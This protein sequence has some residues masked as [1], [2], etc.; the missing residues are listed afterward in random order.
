MLARAEV[1][2]LAVSQVC[3]R[4]LLGLSEVSGVGTKGWRMRGDEEPKESVQQV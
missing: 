1:K 4:M 2:W 3:D